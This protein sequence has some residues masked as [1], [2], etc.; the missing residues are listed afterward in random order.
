M[1]KYIKIYRTMATKEEVEALQEQFQQLKAQFQAPNA[2]APAPQQPLRIIYPP[3]ERKIKKFAGVQPTEGE[4]YPLSDFLDEVN[5]VFSAR[6]N[7]TGAEKADFILSNLEG[8]A[9]DEAKCLASEDQKKEEKIVE[10]LKK[11]FGEKLGLAQLMAKFYARRQ[12]PG[13]DLQKYCRALLLL[14]RRISTAKGCIQ[15]IIRDVFVENVRDSTL[16]RELKRQI[17]GNPE[18]GF[19]AIREA[20]N[21]WEEDADDKPRRSVSL[22]EHEASTESQQG[23]SAQ[24]PDL[25]QVVQQ[26]QKVLEQMAATLKRLQES[27]QPTQTAARGPP[28]Q[29]G[30]GRPLRDGNGQLI[31]YN[32]REPG[33]IGR[34]CP[35]G[36]QVQCQGCKKF[37]HV[38]AECKSQLPRTMAATREIEA[39]TR[40]SNSGNDS[41]QLL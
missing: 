18:V 13:E 30:A 21:H 16:R 27:L 24:G 37:G 25:T 36:T 17:R 15:P 41:Q 31:C 11:V 10:T 39:D 20:A 8:A 32:C 34:D 4:F 35:R 12:E 19:E 33:H 1:V 5:N 28:R 6:D 14:G 29:G 40:S 9:R 2:E 26:Q 7:L 38:L 23:A 3:R 22:H